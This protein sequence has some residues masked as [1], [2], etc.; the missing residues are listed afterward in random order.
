MTSLREFE[1]FAKGKSPTENRNITCVIYT[2]VSTK[3]QA[4]TN[5]SL[6]TQRKTCEEYCK[7]HGYKIMAYFG[8]TYESAKTDERL[9][10]NNMLSFVTKS[11]TNISY[12]IVLSLDRFS[13]SGANAIYITEQLKKKGIIVI[14]VMQPADVTTPSGALQQNIQ[15][16]FS[17]Y[18]NQLRREKTISGMRNKLLKGEWCMKPPRGYDIITINGNRSIVINEEGELLRKAFLWKYY[19]KLSQSEIIDRLRT[20]GLKINCQGMSRLLHNPFYCGIITSNSLQGQLVIGK[21]EKLV[22]KS[23][24]LQVSEG[25]TSD[26]PVRS[27]NADHPDLPLRRLLTCV[28]C[29]GRYTG[30]KAG[31]KNLYYYRCNTKGCGSNRNANDVHRLFAELLIKIKIDE[32][33]HPKLKND[34]ASHFIKIDQISNNQRKLKVNLTTT[35]NKLELL[36]ERYVLKEVSQS[37]Y[38]KYVSKLKEEKKAIE[39]Q[40]DKSRA[41]LL[42][43]EEL[44]QARE[45]VMK[46]LSRLWLTGNLRLKRII[47]NAVFPEGIGFDRSADKLVINKLAPGFTLQNTT[48]RTKKRF[49]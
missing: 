9:E 2:R 14:S 18:D 12:I 35:R 4:E 11:R 47:Q 29:D 38:K 13:R 17:E 16:I 32:K 37:I 21:H 27:N 36:E 43:K 25:L 39:I 8:G 30:Y 48:H 15:F 45:G 7:K 31:K 28:L 6:E 41:G 1:R 34:F 42:S 46:D 20:M 24:F 49:N 44:Y 10:F 40:L 3:E 5:L 26:H 23:L 33:K 19:E 22:S